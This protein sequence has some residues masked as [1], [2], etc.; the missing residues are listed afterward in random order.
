MEKVD[1]D[2]WR[3]GKEP[4]KIRVR[5]KEYF[6]STVEMERYVAPFPSSLCSPCFGEGER[7][8]ER[9]EREATNF[10]PI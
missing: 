1:S 5:Q 8:R 4:K 7:E 10:C 3:G 2:E 9:E 6:V